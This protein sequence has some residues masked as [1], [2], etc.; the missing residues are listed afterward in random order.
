VFTWWEGTNSHPS[1]QLEKQKMKAYQQAW[2]QNLH[3]HTKFA[4]NLL[5]IRQTHFSL[6]L[7]LPSLLVL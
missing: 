6:I 2:K 7:C 5:A 4:M 1:L 3:L